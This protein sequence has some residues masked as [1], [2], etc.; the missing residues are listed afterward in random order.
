MWNNYTISNT[1]SNPVLT[2]K[3][4]NMKRILAITLILGLFS[5]KEPNVE[6]KTT[7]Y[8][9]CNDM[10]PLEIVTIDGCEYLYGPWGNARVLTHKGNCKNPIHQ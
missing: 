10:D 7:T 2:T 9:I 4:R 1:G 6:K 8:R 3:N 5:C